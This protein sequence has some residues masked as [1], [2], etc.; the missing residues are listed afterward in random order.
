MS[1]IQYDDTIFIWKSILKFLLKKCQK[2]YVWKNTNLYE[3]LMMKKMVI[4]V[5]LFFYDMGPGNVRIFKQFIQRK[6]LW[7]N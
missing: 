4:Y 1:E 3:E 6:I 7:R 5:K 2:V